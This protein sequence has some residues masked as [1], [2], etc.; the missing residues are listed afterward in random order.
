[1][2]VIYIFN[3]MT[4]K[5]VELSDRAMIAIRGLKNEMEGLSI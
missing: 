1:M 3:L 5:K 4:V 2:I